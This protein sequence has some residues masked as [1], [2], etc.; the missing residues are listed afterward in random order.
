MKRSSQSHG[1]SKRS[2]RRGRR[3]FPQF[4]H[5]IQGQGVLCHIRPIIINDLR[6]ETNKRSYCK[7]L[8]HVFWLLGGLLS[9]IHAVVQYCEFE[10]V[11]LTTGLPAYTN[12]GYSDTL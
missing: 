7:F 6:R 3:E 12:T 10:Y 2:S 1:Y 4:S 8:F 9:I 11:L 5:T